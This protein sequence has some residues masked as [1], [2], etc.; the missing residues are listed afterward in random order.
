MLVFLHVPFKWHTVMLIKFALDMLKSA[1]F[2]CELSGNS[3]ELSSELVDII[4]FLTEAEEAP[5]LSR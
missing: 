4:E 2:E 3:K 1:A 5:E